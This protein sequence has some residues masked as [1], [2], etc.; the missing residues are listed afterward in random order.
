MNHVQ[1]FAVRRRDRTPIVLKTYSLLP[2]KITKKDA[3]AVAAEE[4][5]FMRCQPQCIVIID[6]R[7]IVVNKALMRYSS[8]LSRAERRALPKRTYVANSPKF[9]NKVWKVI[10]PFLTKDDASNVV[11]HAGTVQETLQLA[12][13]SVA[14]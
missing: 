2:K 10:R 7:N 1:V 6:A 5:I 11:F 8:A 4:S 14:I 13:S 12:S 9:A 3:N